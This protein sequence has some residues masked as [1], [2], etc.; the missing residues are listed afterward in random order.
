MGYK[1]Y[2]VSINKFSDMVKCLIYIFFKIINKFTKLK[3][4]YTF[5]QSQNERWMNG[6]RKYLIRDEFGFKKLSRTFFKSK[7]SKLPDE[8]D[9]RKVGAVTKVKDQMHCQSCYAFSAVSDKN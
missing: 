5:L 8:V 3:K 6:N 9:W 2:R 7:N 1:A 4:Y